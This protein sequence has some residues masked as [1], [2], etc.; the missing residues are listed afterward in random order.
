MKL[1]LINSAWVQAG[2]GNR[3]RHPQDQGDRLR[4]DRHLRRPARH[5]RQGEAADQG[6]MRRGRPADRERRLRRRRARSTSTP[7][8]SGSTSSGSGPIS[9]WRTCSRRKNV[10]LVLGEYIWQKEV[11]P[12][13][14]QWA[15]AVKHVRALGEYAGEPRPGDRARARAV[16]ALAPERRARA[17]RGSSTTSTTRP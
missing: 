8:S 6:R 13:A 10:L 7:A 9:T 5:R 12:P 16:R 4:L 1:G 11:I 3:V 14:E 17:W 2:R 15:T